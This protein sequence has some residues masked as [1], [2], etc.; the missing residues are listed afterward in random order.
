[1]YGVSRGGNESLQA[2][3][4]GIDAAELQNRYLPFLD[5][6]PDK[7]DRARASGDGGSGSAANHG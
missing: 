1:M 4:A 6:T 2:L 5:L 3:K 7:T